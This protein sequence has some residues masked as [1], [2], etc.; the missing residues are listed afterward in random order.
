MSKTLQVG[1]KDVSEVEGPGCCGD[2]LGMVS[3]A[4]REGV[5]R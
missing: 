3:S 5:I 4:R 1:D 2:E